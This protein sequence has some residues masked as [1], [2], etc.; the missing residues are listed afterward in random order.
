MFLLRDDRSIEIVRIALIDYFEDQ[1]LLLCDPREW[2]LELEPPDRLVDVRFVDDQVPVTGCWTAEPKPPGD[3]QQGL[4]SEGH[5]DQNE[6]YRLCFGPLPDMPPD[7]V[8][9]NEHQ[10]GVDQMIVQK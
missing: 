1:N 8:K 2:S 7:S 9:S 5:K 4:Q 3:H 10:K 6:A